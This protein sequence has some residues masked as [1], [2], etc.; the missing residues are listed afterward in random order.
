MFEQLLEV[1]RVM[2]RNGN[3]VSLYGMIIYPCL[4]GGRHNQTREIAFEH[5]LSHLRS[6]FQI[7]ALLPGTKTTKL[8]MTG[9]FAFPPPVAGMS[10]STTPRSPL[11]SSAVG[12]QSL[13]AEQ[14]MADESRPSKQSGDD[15]QSHNRRLQEEQYQKRL[16]RER[17]DVWKAELE[18]VR[19]GGVLRDVRGRRDKART[20]I[21]RAEVRLQNEERAIL[22]RWNTY[23][24]RWRKLL[25][26]DDLVCW[27][28]IPWPVQDPPA[29]I[30][31]LTPA[32]IS[33]FLF[34]PLKVR[35]ASGT[36]KDKLRQALLRWHPDKLAM[37]IS[38]VVDMEDGKVVE[39]INA[40]FRCLR[41]LQDVDK[42]H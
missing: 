19:S 34:A 36:R 2:D 39:G 12:N 27:M 5:F 1:V 38:R 16:E 9:Y 29:S 3:I 32:A 23:E 33:D 18:W 13:S 10:N 4:S 25:T 17:Q 28:D 22:T 41:E 31:Q 20:E 40:V 24:E 7:L 37:L 8:I 35:E 42:T 26:S 11:T 30:E 21:L 15:P 6:F 14:L